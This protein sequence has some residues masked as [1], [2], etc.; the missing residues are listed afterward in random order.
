MGTLMPITRDEIQSGT[1]SV[2]TGA[3]PRSERAENA[4]CCGHAV[5]SNFKPERDGDVK[6]YESFIV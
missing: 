6:T 2:K 5:K 1:A 4:F 3:K